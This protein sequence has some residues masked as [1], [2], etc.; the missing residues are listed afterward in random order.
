MR[1]KFIISAPLLASSLLVSAC[2]SAPEPKPAKPVEQPRPPVVKPAPPVA[3]T[4][5]GNWLDWKIAPGDWAY[6]Q[7]DRG[8]IA[9]FG[10]VGQDATVTL[11]CDKARQRIYLSRLGDFAGPQS[12][13]MRS[14]S[15]TRN[16]QGQPTGG[17]PGYIA[18][19]LAPSDK[20]L[21]DIAYT[22]GR[23]ALE[24][25]GSPSIAVPVY[26]EVSRVIEDCR[27]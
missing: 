20:G 23:I 22:R 5:T 6:R 15:A 8:S 13:T 4:P 17:T 3:A 9:L 7:D 11:R 2:V 18:A 21:D 26:A 16:W 12:I 19:E 14:S 10:P 1:T 27:G 24:I 25:A